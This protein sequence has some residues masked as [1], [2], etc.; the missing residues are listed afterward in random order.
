MELAFPLLRIPILPSLLLLL[1]K[2]LS[3]LFHLGV[4]VCRG[5]LLLSLRKVLIIVFF[6]GAT[7]E[8][9][10]YIVCSLMFSGAMH[11]FLHSVIHKTTKACILIMSSVNVCAIVLRSEK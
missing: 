2:I 4:Q 9:P 1:S 8:A 7:P 3:F 5:N 6:L 11:K 10:A